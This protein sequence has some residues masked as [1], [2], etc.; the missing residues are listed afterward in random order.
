MGR[1][2]FGI[3]G[4]V[5]NAGT[6]GI[7]WLDVARAP[8]GGSFSIPLVVAHGA[9]DGPTLL[10]EAC[11]HGDEYEGT[12][13]VLAVLRDLDPA[14]LRGT[15]IAVPVLNGPAFEAETRGNP[16]E[17][18][19]Y[20]LNRS[21]PGEHGG[22]VTQRI[23]AR[24]FD[25]V[26][27]RANVV[28]SLHGGGNVFYLDGFVVAHATSGNAMELIRAMGWKRFTDTPD[29]ALNPY[30]GTL[31]EKCNEL[32]IP[33]IVAEFGG[34]SRR[35]PADI[36]RAKAEFSRGIRNVMVHYGMLDGDVE[37]PAVLEKIKKQN[38]RAGNGGIIEVA[39]GVDI[40][41]EVEAGQLLLTVLD[42]LG[43][44]VERIVAPF[45]GRVMALPG[46]PLAYPGRI[47]TTVYAVTEQLPL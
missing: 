23:A 47:L 46:S 17:R 9:V 41:A 7:G 5:V 6:K 36:E 30:Q 39:E 22:S 44:E 10:L 3:A 29:V 15:V 13:A 19:H 35:S 33:T 26:V 40:G 43:A 4:M 21:F 25:E 16:L 28:V 24:Y 12:L 2:P 8:A 11:A 37:R 14:N 32:G 31:W 42:P 27:K 38:M 1:E 18:Y 34:A 20:D 45:D